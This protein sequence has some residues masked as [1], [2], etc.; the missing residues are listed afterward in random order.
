[1][2]NQSTE[3]CRCIH[4]AYAKVHRTCLCSDC[5]VNKRSFYGMNSKRLNQ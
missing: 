2:L 5:R 3:T 1:M 4:P